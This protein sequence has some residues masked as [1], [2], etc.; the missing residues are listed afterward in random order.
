MT[1]TSARPLRSDAARNQERILDAAREIFGELGPEAPLE[2][3]ARRA[4]VGI[5]TLFRRFPRKEHLIRAVIAQSLDAHVTPALEKASDLEDPRQGLVSALESVL[6]TVA[7]ERSTL[8]AAEATGALTDELI[9]PVLAPI[10][11]L[12]QRAQ[13]DGLLRADL[14]EADVPRLLGMLTSAILGAPAGSEGWRRYLA[15]ILDAFDPEKSG[16][17]P[18]IDDDQSAP[19]GS[20]CLPHAPANPAAGTAQVV[21]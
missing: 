14:T 8:A 17:L 15:L 13:A 2:A 5:R 12:T 10:A 4:G 3:V 9:S 7:R 21:P 16:S 11:Q 6:E 20:R 19:G 1:D 18:P